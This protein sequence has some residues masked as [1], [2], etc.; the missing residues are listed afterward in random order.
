MFDLSKKTFIRAIIGLILLRVFLVVLM[1]NNIP[2]TDM[3]PGGFRPNFGGSYFPDEIH[4][5]EMAQS[6]AKFSPIPN[7]ANLGYPLFLA[8]I[9]RFIGAAGPEDI[10]KIVF[11]IN[12]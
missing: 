12:K 9:I 1:M 5:F 6:F 7:A 8:P 11:I 2:F 4:F 10:A 3:Q